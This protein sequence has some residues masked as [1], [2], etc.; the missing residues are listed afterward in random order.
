MEENN[1]RERK[2][3]SRDWSPEK[4]RGRTVGISGEILG[5]DLSAPWYNIILFKTQSLRHAQDEYSGSLIRI[6]QNCG[7][8]RTE[9]D[10][11]ITFDRNLEGKA[12]LLKADSEEQLLLQQEYIEKIKDI[13]EGYEHVRYFGGIGK[14]GEPSAGAS[15]IFEQASHA[16]AHRYLVQDSRI[17]DGGHMDRERRR[18]AL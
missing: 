9:Q 2:N 16:F 11:S 1:L 12:F 6:E 7:D 13:M 8:W 15:D 14:T 4:H 17:L 5:I 3:C 18:R 10:G